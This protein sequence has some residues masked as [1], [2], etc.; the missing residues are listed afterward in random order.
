MASV[1]TL[2]TQYWHLGLDELT[3]E[4]M[5]CVHSLTG[6]SLSHGATRVVRH[7][8]DSSATLSHD[9]GINEATLRIDES[10]SRAGPPGSQ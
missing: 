7:L 10:S 3:G 1:K 5:H 6:Q 8:G 2:G 9:L 4:A